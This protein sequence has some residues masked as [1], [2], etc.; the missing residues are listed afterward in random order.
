MP[1][2]DPLCKRSVFALSLALLLLCSL[3]S[4][5]PAAGFQAAA[6]KA[7]HTWYVRLDGG[8]RK[9]CTGKVD[10]PYHGHGA[11]QPCAFKHPQNLFT[12][13]ERDNRAWI[14]AGGD[15]IIIRGG[16]YRMGYTGPNPYDFPGMC[17]G[18]PFGCFMPP[19]PSGEENHPTRILGEQFASC[20][21]KTQLFGGYGLGLVLNLGGS[22]HVDVECIELTAHGTCSRVGAN[23]PGLKQCNTS[24]PVS[25][26][27][28]TGIATSQETA[29][30]TL[31]N[32][33]IHGFAS[34]GII[35]AIGGNVFID[36]VR[37]AF[38]AGAGWDFDDGKGTRSSPSAS[39][40][41]SNLLVEWN[42]CNEEYP[43]Q[44]AHPAASCFDQDHG[45]YGDG[46]GTPDTPLNF[47]CDHCVFR[48]NTQDGFDLLHTSGSEIAV[49]NSESYGN[50]GQQWKMGAMHSVVF[51]NNI[52]IH[53][54]S[55]LSAAMDGVP[56]GYNRSLDLFCRA[57]G[58]G[59]AFVVTNDGAYIFQ[60]NTYIGYGTTSYDI[61]CNGTC[62]RPNITF[63][64]NINVG[65]K[66]P[67]DGQPPAVFYSEGL[68]KNP[69][70]ARD[71]NIYFHMRTCPSGGSGSS[72]ERCIDPQLKS[73][74]A[75]TGESSLDHLDLH[76]AAGSP[77]RG[78]GAS[79]HDLHNDATGA[80]RPEGAPTDLGAFL[81]H[82]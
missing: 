26:Y 67:H 37:I 71:H 53:N 32:L 5:S 18:D 63:Q 65:Y 61:S 27:S 77:A 39:V 22:K 50:M 74:P 44:H 51:R 24:Y 16:P 62:S 3:V 7:D 58:D 34:R 33:D 82:P 59:I 72:Q 13:G 19:V 46:I 52:T 8:D 21:A 42:G 41:A 64:N 4:A 20:G 1:S 80:P 9:Q 36:H 40:H 56:D 60:N 43:I 55:R 25:D 79:I 30:L 23:S 35:G 47:T 2:L 28:G 6:A 69:F 17:P 70:Q 11:S 12:N 68:S 31:R 49:T 54:C 15:T 45:G 76:L 75:W 38:N 48:Y 14:I 29:D 10:A 81:Y 66:N 57:S 73:L 78:S